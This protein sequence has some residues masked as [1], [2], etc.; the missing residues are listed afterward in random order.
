VNPVTELKKYRF[1]KAEIEDLNQ[2][3]AKETSFRRRM[4][5]REVKQGFINKLNRNKL[6]LVL[7]VDNE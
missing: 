3:I 7:G 4:L 5:F 6:S 1:Y 2:R